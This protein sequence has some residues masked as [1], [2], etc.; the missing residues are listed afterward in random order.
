MNFEY[1]LGGLAV[2]FM[3]G[4]LVYNWYFWLLVGSVCAVAMRASTEPVPVP[5]GPPEGSPGGVRAAY[6]GG[7]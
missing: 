2:I 3:L 1:A 6:R 7:V 5:V 4:Y